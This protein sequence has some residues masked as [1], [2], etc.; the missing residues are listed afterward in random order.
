LPFDIRS[1][2]VIFNNDSIGGKPLAE[3]TLREHLHS[4]LIRNRTAIL[5]AGKNESFADDEKAVAGGRAKRCHG[6]F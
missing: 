6:G 3:R 2:R 5:H 1:Y 4:I